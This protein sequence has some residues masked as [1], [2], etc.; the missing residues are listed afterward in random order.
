MLLAFIFLKF[1]KAKFIL[2]SEI[3]LL[4]IG[5]LAVTK[6]EL[7]TIIE[8]VTFKLNPTFPASSGPKLEKTIG[9]KS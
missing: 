2:F 4:I 9:V 3:N 6:E 7:M 8:L 1:F 5:I